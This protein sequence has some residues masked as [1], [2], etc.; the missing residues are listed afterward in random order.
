MEPMNCTALVTDNGFEVWASTQAPENA[1]DAAAEAAGLPVSEGNLHVTQIGGGFGRRRELDY[2]AQAVQIAKAMKGT[3]IKLIWSRDA[4]R[5]T[6]STGRRIFHA[7]AEQSIRTATPP[8]GHTGSS[9]LRAASLSASSV[10]PAF[11]IPFLTF[12]SILW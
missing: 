5:D 8:P 10:R 2:V 1:L 9:P 3:P 7:C 11:H 6:A 4:P 12:W